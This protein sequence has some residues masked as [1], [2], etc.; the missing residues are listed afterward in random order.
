LAR[1]GEVIETAAINVGGRLVALDGGRVAR[2]EPAAREVANEL[3]LGLVLN[4]SFPPEDQRRLADTLAGCLFEVI[5]RGRLSD[6]TQRLLVTPPLSSIAPVDAVVFSG[7]VSEYVYGREN[8][9]FGD[10]APLLAAAIQKRIDAGELPAAVVPAAECIRATVIG[11][12]Q[13]TVQ[14]S[15]S[16]IYVSRPDLL[17]VHNLPVLAPRLPRRERQ[18]PREM[19]E[20]IRRS[21]QR[22]DLDDG[23]QPVALAIDWEGM[24]A[25]EH[26]RALADGIMVGLPRAL[27]AQ[28]PITLVFA[29]DHGELVGRIL[30]QDIG[31]ANDVISVDC[32]NLGDF[33]YIDIGELIPLANVVPVVVKSLLFPEARAAR[34]ELSET[35]GV[36]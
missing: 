23:E 5:Q 29:R 36:N 8:R 13:F 3:G 18:D 2:I 9:D 35:Q 33:D 21:L 19:G 20:A 30:H 28:L 16:T 10:L 17:P 15:G 31:I 4:E 32:V 26:L 7:G 12:S 11:A 25:Y 14:V 22:F 1:D 24:P 6:L 27:A 34:A